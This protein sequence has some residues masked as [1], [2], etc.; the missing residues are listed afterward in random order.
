MLEECHGF[1]LHQIKF[2]Q[3][4]RNSYRKLRPNIPLHLKRDWEALFSD[5][6]VDLFPFEERE[7]HEI[8][9]PYVAGR[10]I[11][12]SEIFVGREDVFDFLKRNLRGPQGDNILI[13]HGRRRTGKSSILYQIS[14]RDLLEPSVSVY[15][16]LQNVKPKITTESEKH[17]TSLLV[18]LLAE[19]I[20]EAVE[21][22]QINSLKKLNEYQWRKSPLRTFD[23]FLD[24][25]MTHLKDR[26]LVLLIDEFE[27]LEDLTHEGF[28]TSDIFPYLRSL[29]QHKPRVNFILAGAH[30]L[31]EM[32]SDYWSIL[33]NI[34]L[35]YRIGFLKKE[36]VYKLIREPVSAFLSY[37]DL[38]VKSIFRLTGGQPYFLQLTC[39]CLVNHMNEKRRNLATARDVEEVVDRVIEYGSGEFTHHWDTF[40]STLCQ[41]LTAALAFLIV[42]PD[43]YISV[44]D[45]SAL[46]KR[47]GWHFQKGELDQALHTLVSTTETLEN[48][49]RNPNEIRFRMDL[50]RRW[51]RSA[52][53][54]ELWQLFRQADSRQSKSSWSGESENPDI[55]HQENLP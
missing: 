39:H 21:C 22:H 37:D 53:P 34:A 15:I 41:K 50:F 24:D 20:T 19:K 54:K 25:V 7:Y 14:N 1:A 51:L 45:L 23:R 29:M 32:R 55:D 49:E 3:Q 17:G 8:P 43:D 47:A 48:Y 13:L 40:P 10:P 11:L 31:E 28:I 35:F 42:D 18:E 33:F 30:G 38:A 27:G 36:Q 46:I 5:P 44:A 12:S 16:D 2:L 52:P 26:H 6:A 9:N 4:Y